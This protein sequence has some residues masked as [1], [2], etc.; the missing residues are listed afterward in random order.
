MTYV[1]QRGGDIGRPNEY[2][3]NVFQTPLTYATQPTRHKWCH[4]LTRVWA[5]SNIQLQAS[6]TGLFTKFIFS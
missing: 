1:A 6:V 3:Q 4:L 2:D 5:T